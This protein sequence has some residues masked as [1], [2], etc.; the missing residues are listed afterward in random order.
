[1]GVVFIFS[2]VVRIS[3][4]ADAAAADTSRL[5]SLSLLPVFFLFLFLFSFGEALG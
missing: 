5:S 4:H 3:G 1:M 2:L